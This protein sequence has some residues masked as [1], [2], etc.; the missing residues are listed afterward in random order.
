MLTTFVVYITLFFICIGGCYIVTNIRKISNRY[1]L[2]FF[3]IASIVIGG[4]YK[5]GADWLNYL[6]LFLDC[7]NYP[8]S[9]S[10]L[11]QDG[12][13]PL[14]MILNYLIVYMGGTPSVFFATIAFLIF[15][16]LY[17]SIS[18]DIRKLPLLIFFYFCLYLAFSFNGLR[19]A[20]SMAVFFCAVNYIKF[21]KSKYIVIVTIATL[22]HYSSAILYPFVLIDS[23]IFN[24][25]DKKL[26]VIFAYVITLIFSSILLEYFISWIPLNLLSDKY[27]NNL[28]SL[29]QQHELSSGL[30]IVAHK[31]VDIYLIVMYGK[32]VKDCP[33]KSYNVYYRCFVVGALLTNVMGFSI[34][35]ARVPM[36]LYAL[37]IYLLTYTCSYLFKSN[38]T[39]NRIMGCS[40]MLL[41]LLMFI[42]QI[43]QGSIDLSPFV[44]QWL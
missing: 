18:D 11:E 27:I 6:A 1:C 44:F 33:C 31:I 17:Y 16:L 36:C 9:F 37:K 3:F 19:Q 13:E 30:G 39:C 29:D 43:L 7:V 4:R 26:Y 25:I 38:Q 12:Y 42:V 40:L 28:G 2:F 15:I 41:Y 32:V 5:V 35:L 20:I 21:S 34:Y 14:Y 10:M 8:F 24:V 22:F 23:K